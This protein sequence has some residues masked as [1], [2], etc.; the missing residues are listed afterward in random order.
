MVFDLSQISNHKI[1]TLY[2]S[3]LKGEPKTSVAAVQSRMVYAHMHGRS[4]RCT[5]WNINNLT[6]HKCHT[7]LTL[8]YKHLLWHMYTN[9]FKINEWGEYVRKCACLP[10]CCFE[11]RETSG[12]LTF[13]FR[14]DDRCSNMNQEVCLLQDVY[15]I[16]FD[17]R[18]REV[19]R[20]LR[21][22]AL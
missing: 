9:I 18:F 17:T 13:L 15:K 14:E 10:Y 20:E 21:W 4:P 19:S 6:C 1:I 3:L 12:I 16:S 5:E 8:K 7:L 2:T 11:L 22:R